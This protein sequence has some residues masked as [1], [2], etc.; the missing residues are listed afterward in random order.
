[1][2]FIDDIV[3]DN[4]LFFDPVNGFGEAATYNGTAI[5]VVEDGG[6]ESNIG[7]PGVNVGN[8]T[9]YVQRADVAT[10]KQGD[11]V[12]FRGVSCYVTGSPRCDADI[13]EVQIMAE[14]PT[15]IGVS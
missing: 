5:T 2:T 12:V 14:V 3:A 9:L 6:D 15:R 1:M 10:P 8:Y 13:W 11:S 7:I 4:T